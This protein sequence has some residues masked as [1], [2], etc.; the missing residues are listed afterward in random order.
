MK[1]LIKLFG[2]IAIVVIIGFVM[3][4]CKDDEEEN[5]FIVNETSGRLTVT[6]IPAQYNGKWIIG[7]GTPNLRAGNGFQAPQGGNS[8][9]LKGVQIVSGSA[10]LKVWTVRDENTMDSYTGND[11]TSFYLFINDVEV[12][13]GNGVLGSIDVTFSNGIASGAFI[14]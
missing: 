6:G 5:N 4:A 9:K 1:K 10:T 14:L 2:I 3:T 12:D 8:Y 13:N 11:K 7:V